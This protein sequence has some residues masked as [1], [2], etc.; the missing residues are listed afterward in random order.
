[1]KV[2]TPC[3]VEP[4]PSTNNSVLVAESVGWL[5]SVCETVVPVSTSTCSVEATLLG[6]VVVL[7]I[8]VAN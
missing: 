4:T 8:G 1:M 2:D 3:S 6:Y 5:D 7:R